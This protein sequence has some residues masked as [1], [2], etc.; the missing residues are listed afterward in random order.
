MSVLH[1]IKI[2][3]SQTT[4]VADATK[5]GR[6]GHRDFP[7]CVV[8]YI[9]SGE[10]TS[11]SGFPLYGV[12]VA[13]PEILH[14]RNQIAPACTRAGIDQIRAGYDP[15]WGLSCGLHGPPSTR[16]TPVDYYKQDLAN[17]AKI[18]RQMSKIFVLTST[19]SVVSRPQYR[20]WTAVPR[21]RHSYYVRKRVSAETVSSILRR[22]NGN[23]VK[24]CFVFLYEEVLR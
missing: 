21:H 16:L 7:N 2:I 20:L 22:I 9:T 13:S 3:E 10:T 1:V 23:F 18:C 24:W 19:V 8:V 11:A 5:S 4:F 17:R 14:R 6:S 15:C 12:R